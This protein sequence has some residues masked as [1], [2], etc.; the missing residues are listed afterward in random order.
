MG[1]KIA[2]LYLLSVFCS[3]T[4]SDN[5]KLSDYS[6][7]FK[8]IFETIFYKLQKPAKTYDYMLFHRLT[9]F[10]SFQ[11]DSYVFGSAKV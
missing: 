3:H 10:L 2:C 11:E 7:I 6:E 5:A 4:G 9:R 8:E 1:F